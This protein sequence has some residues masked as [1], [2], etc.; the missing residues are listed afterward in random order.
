MEISKDVMDDVI[1]DSPNC[2]RALS[3]LLAKHKTEIEGILKEAVRPEDRATKYRE[4]TS[5]FLRRPQT[6]F[7]L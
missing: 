7:A 5:N 1:R 6:F 2:L 3:E 4:Y